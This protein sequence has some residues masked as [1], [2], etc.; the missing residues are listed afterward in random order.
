MRSKEVSKAIKVIQRDI[1]DYEEEL[2]IE[3]EFEDGIDEQHVSYL[4]QQKT[5]Y[6][7]VLNYISELEKKNKDAKEYAD[8]VWRKQ[9]ELRAE[10]DKL[11][12]ELIEEKQFN[13]KCLKLRD[14]EYINKQ[15]IRDEIKELKEKAKTV[16][17]VDLLILDAKI[18]ML[19]R[20]IIGE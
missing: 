2:E 4:I 18:N 17:G 16:Q 15:V 8:D 9:E 10:K 3:I 12:D 7:T 13:V 20:I 14:E 1:T 6:E 5:S 11:Q 19:E